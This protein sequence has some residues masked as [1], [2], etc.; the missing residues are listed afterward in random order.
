MFRH[1]G[2]SRTLKHNL[3]IATVLSFVAGLVNV[4]GF[5]ALKQLTTNVTGHFALFIND[6]ANLEFWRGTVY[7]LYIFS[8]F[9]GSFSSS[10]LI[11][12]NTARKKLNVFFIPTMIQVVI[13]V[14]I[15]I[16]QVELMLNYVDVAACL[17]LFAMGMQNS[18]VTKIS[19]AIVRTTHLTGLFTDLGIEISQLFF[20]ELHH[21]EKL[22]ETIKLRIFI[23]LFFFAGGLI[24]GFLYSELDLE[25]NTLLFGA[26]VLLISLFYDDLRFRV[27]RKKRK[28]KHKKISFHKLKHIE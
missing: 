15:A 18:Y 20:P 27:I 23:I 3:Q 7:F 8:F 5:L 21:R 28:Y 4:S 17:L 11:E 22:K 2:K 26:I 25:L 9:F 12:I 10:L 24:G 14:G 1:Q 6:V 13:L 16:F 19:K